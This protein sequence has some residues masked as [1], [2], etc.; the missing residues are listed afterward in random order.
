[1][2][3][4]PYVDPST[5]PK[6]VREV[7]DNL[8][9]LNIFKMVANSETT[10]RPFLGL[11][12]ALLA[13]KTFDHKLRELVILQVGKVSDGRY[14]WHQHVPIA[15]AVGASDDQIA[16]LERG[17]IGAD[18]FDDT[19]KAVLHFTTDAVE[20]VRASDESFAA[21]NAHLSPA[22]I[23]ELIMILGFYRTVAMLTESTDIEIDDPAGTAVIDALK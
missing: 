20:N 8:P 9:Q 17:D 19:E 22:Q 23:V 4:L 11:G 18:C 16:A 13:S 3:R 5:A 7:L 2:A 10:F 15:K 6:A 21:V 14:E 12:T 1:M